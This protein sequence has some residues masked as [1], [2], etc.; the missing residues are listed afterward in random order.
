MNYKKL[1]IPSLFILAIF[2]SWLSP[3]GRPY[4]D[5]LDLK[6]FTF[7]N[8]WVHHSPFWQG[9]WAFTGSKI[10]DWIHDIVMIS[11]FFLAIKW[12]T[13]ELKMRK[14]A[15]LIF[16]ALLIGC[17]I[18]IVTGSIFS[19]MIHLPRYSPTLVANE[20]FRLS[21][22]VDWIK[23]KDQSRRSFP[24]DHGITAIL[25]AAL[26]FHLMGK[27]MGLIAIFYAIFFCLPRLVAGAHWLTDNLVGSALIALLATSIAFGTPLANWAITNIERGLNK[28]IRKERWGDGRR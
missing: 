14:V 9:F 10:M 12:S 7:F 3:Q 16:S 2:V 22:A 11:F 5:M 25:F 19:K 24:G 28:L 21:A 15:E 1:L 13:K 18:W 26:V 23:V 20:A 6:A 27:R 17:M 4:W 8:S